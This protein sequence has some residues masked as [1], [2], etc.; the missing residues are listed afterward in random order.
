MGIVYTSNKSLEHPYDAVDQGKIQDILIDP[1]QQEPTYTMA[2]L[3]MDEVT[4]ILKKLDSLAFG[5][6]PQVSLM[7]A[8][9]A[10][11][12]IKAVQLVKA[13]T[14]QQFRGE[15]AQGA[16]LDLRFLRAKDV[17]GAIL[18]PAATG[19]LFLYQGA[20]AV[21]T[22]LHAGVLA[23][24]Y[25]MVMSQTM[26]QWAA[27]VY[28][29]FINP[30]EVPSIDA[31]QFTLFGVAVPAQSADFRMIKTFGVNEL[32]AVKLEKPIIVPPLGIQNLDVYNY[33]TG[34]DK[35]QPVAILV[36]RSQ[37]LTI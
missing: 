31:F 3:S 16:A 23:T 10:Y 2:S 11:A 4:T 33:R 15:F 28:L 19:N 30:I 27:L 26:E 5:N 35:T 29:G 7:I 34:D 6:S 20:A 25:H 17:G 32:P 8:E 1:S 12:V 37:E 24:T 36:A 18:N 13:Q 9:G 14:K 21:N 22:F